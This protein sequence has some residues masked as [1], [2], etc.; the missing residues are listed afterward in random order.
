MSIIY[1]GMVMFPRLEKFPIKH[2]FFLFG[3]RGTGK[4]TLLKLRFE[5]K[6]CIWLDLLDSRIEERFSLNPYDLIDIV[7]SLPPEK[8]YIVID[9][10]QKIPKLLDIVHLLIEEQKDK[11]FI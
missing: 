8:I 2:S 10:I 9:E 6:N 4:S 1:G 11:I 5:K 7:R 3:P